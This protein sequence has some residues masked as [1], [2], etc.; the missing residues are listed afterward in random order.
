MTD[1]FPTNPITDAASF[2]GIEI[3]KSDSQKERFRKNSISFD[4]YLSKK[5]ECVRYRRH[6]RENKIVQRTFSYTL[7]NAL[8]ARDSKKVYEKKTWMQLYTRYRKHV[9][10]EDDRYTRTGKKNASVTLGFYWS[11]LYLVKPLFTFG[12]RTVRDDEFHVVQTSNVGVFYCEMVDRSDSSSGSSSSSGGL[13]DGTFDPKHQGRF[14]TYRIPPRSNYRIDSGKRYVLVTYATTLFLLER[15]ARGVELPDISDCWLERP[16]P[17]DSSDP[18]VI[19][20]KRPRSP[21]DD[22]GRRRQKRRSESS[23]FTSE[24]ATVASATTT[25]TATTVAE[26]TDESLAWSSR[27]EVPPTPM[28]S[29]TVDY[30]DDNNK[31]HHHVEKTD[32]PPP[33]PQIVPGVSLVHPYLFDPFETRDFEMI[34]PESGDRFLWRCER[35]AAATATTPPT[36]TAAAAAATTDGISNNFGNRNLTP[37][38]STPAQNFDEFIFWAESSLTTVGG[39]STVDPTTVNHPESE[40]PSAP[41][42]M[43]IGFGSSISEF[44]SDFLLL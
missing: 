1:V 28:P 9:D 4:C 18:T 29:E 31:E 16:K 42:M 5:T 13:P 6:S 22:D 12:L 10:D 15:V 20:N 11:N 39:P 37:H 36:T 27:M 23:P 7:E 14:R 21:E 2:V 24:A 30:G 43:Q 41:T 34:H 44:P 40:P 19:F 3:P 33:Y 38:H 26:P 32:E 17:V 35:F 8:K 25:A